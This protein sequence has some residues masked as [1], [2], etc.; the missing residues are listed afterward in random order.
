MLI[1][2]SPLVYYDQVKNQDILPRRLE[3]F[4]IVVGDPGDMGSRNG[5]KV[6]NLD[7]PAQY[8]RVDVKGRIIHTSNV[9]NLDFDPMVWKELVTIDG[10]E[11]DVAAE[12]TSFSVCKSINGWRIVATQAQRTDTKRSGRQLGSMTAL[13]R[14]QGPFIVRHAGSNPMSHIALQISRNLHQYFQADTHIS[15][16]PSYLIPSNSTGNVITLAVGSSLGSQNGF[17]IRVDQSSIT[18]RTYRGQVQEYGEEAR[19]AAFLRPLEGERLDL[20]LWGADEEGLRQAARIVPM[21]TGVGQPDF[22]VFG[23][24]VKWRGIEGALAMGFFDSDWEITGSS[25]VETA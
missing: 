21:L 7:D 25:I 13:L 11:F 12:T 15:S 4:S 8:G 18:V 5:I 9:K 2:L 14:S 16:S 10:Q 17:P 24:S 23:E 20:V 1:V 6:L 3:S 19:S 22:V